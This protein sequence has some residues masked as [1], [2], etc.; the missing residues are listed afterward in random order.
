MRTRRRQL[1]VAGQA[2]VIDLLQRAIDALRRVDLSAAEWEKVA[3]HVL[4]AEALVQG[5]LLRFGVRV[6]A[7]AEVD[8]A[9]EPRIVEGTAVTG[10]RSR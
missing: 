9:G 8:E 6:V 2:K 4:S 1:T 5:V 3:P 7:R 10:G